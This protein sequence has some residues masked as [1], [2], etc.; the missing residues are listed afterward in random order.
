[1]PGCESRSPDRSQWR[2]SLIRDYED[3]GATCFGGQKFVSLLHTFVAGVDAPIA[4]GLGAHV[5]GFTRT[6]G[7]EK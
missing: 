4:I 7:Q 3:V 2:A 1:M 6:R 5:S